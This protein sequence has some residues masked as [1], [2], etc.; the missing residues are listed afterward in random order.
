MVFELKTKISR[1]E[2]FVLVPWLHF[3]EMTCNWRIR[4]LYAMQKEFAN[5]NW[6]ERKKTKIADKSKESA[7]FLEL[8]KP[9]KNSDA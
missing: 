2:Y 4:N 8:F 7:Y 3:D 1:W 6:I 9:I 5:A